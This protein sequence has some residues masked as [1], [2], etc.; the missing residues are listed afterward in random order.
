MSV[1]GQSLGCWW[2]DCIHRLQGCSL[3]VAGF[4]LLMGEAGTKARV[5]LKEGCTGAQV[6]VGLVLAHW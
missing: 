5:G 4:C 2:V 3:L 6:I 1:P